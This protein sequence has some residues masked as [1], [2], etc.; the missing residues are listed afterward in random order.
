MQDLAASRGG[1]GHL[2]TKADEKG[3]GAL[4]R[5]QFKTAVGRGAPV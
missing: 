3:A 1:M 5:A 2:R 4:S